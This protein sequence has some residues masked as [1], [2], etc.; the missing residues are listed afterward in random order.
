MYRKPVGVAM[1]YTARWPLKTK[2]ISV[3]RESLWGTDY[4]GH[5]S[6]LCVNENIPWDILMTSLVG[7]LR[8]DRPVHKVGWTRSW[9]HENLT[10]W[11]KSDH[12]SVAASF[13]NR[14]RTA[15]RPQEG[16]WS[17]GFWPESKEQ[18]KRSVLTTQTSCTS[19]RQP[20]PV[21]LRF[22]RSHL[23]WNLHQRRPM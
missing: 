3:L 20:R 21:R 14:Q 13:S 15:T 17:H 19:A 22:V 11:P 5:L 8:W 18:V 23:Y 16:H 1:H 2:W 6:M 9:T 12:L 10:G 7:S 4:W